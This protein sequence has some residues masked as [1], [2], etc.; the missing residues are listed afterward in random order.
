[1]TTPLVPP[2]R[3]NFD[4]TGWSLLYEW[5]SKVQRAIVSAVGTVT[6]FSITPGNGLSG[7]VT[8]PTTT[9]ALTLS[10]TVTGILK[11]NG[12]AISAAINADL[13]AMSATVGGAVPTPPNSSTLFL[14]GQGAFTAPSSGG[15]TIYKRFKEDFGATG[16]GV[17][18]ENTA[19]T[20]FAAALPGFIGYIN[21]GKYLLTGTSGL[22]AM[23][24][25]YLGGSFAYDDSAVAML[26]GAGPQNSILNPRTT[27]MYAIAANSN[28]ASAVM[29]VT[30]KDFTI[31]GRGNVGLV[32]GI[33]L[34][35]PEMQTLDNLRF[36]QLNTGLYA[37]SVEF[38][39]IRK[40]LF[41]QNVNGIIA[42]LGT[43]G[44]THF[45]DGTI[46]DCLF[47]NNSANGLQVTDNAATLSIIGG[48]T[49]N[50]GVMGVGGTAGL[51]LTFTGAEGAN[52]VTI[53]GMYFEG[54]RGD[55]DI[56][57]TNTGSFPVVH[58]IKG[59]NFN[60]IDNTNFTTHNIT[61]VGPNVLLLIGCTFRGFNTYVANAGRSYINPS[62]GTVV[63]PIGCSFS[64]STESAH[65]PPQGNKGDY[66]GNL[67]VSGGSVAGSTLPTGWSAAY[68]GV[69]I[70]RFT[71][72]LNSSTYL[73]FTQ[74]LDPGFFATAYI[75]AITANTFDIQTKS[76]AYANVDC[77]FLFR[78][79]DVGVIV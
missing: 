56:L 20:N 8:N 25:T 66:Y 44:F 43:G 31:S 49:S 76:S 67:A 11:G 55:N 38:F 13:P 72:N 3:G 21:K 33:V 17:T 79:V 78:V 7:T 9:P 50:N 39:T 57:L 41:E 71:H 37:N 51:N 63:I 46:Q 77:S 59:C 15:S 22:G 42:T 1:M 34:N 26:M 62:A 28:S 47:D 48:I 27:G 74:I 5:L 32:N 10:T 6:S 36:E 18:N 60:R 53:D 64:S 61:T 65:L 14:N 58:V 40:C 52:G 73:P 12:T 45:N 30:Y 75:T 70:Y 29:E 24:F 68:I 4:K 54:N 19:A 69:G 2:P 16:D 23:T 35:V